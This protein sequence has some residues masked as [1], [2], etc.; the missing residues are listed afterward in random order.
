[1]TDQSEFPPLPSNRSF[2]LL[3]IAVFALLGLWQ[4]W[5]GGSSWIWFGLAGTTGFVTVIAPGLL[6]P[7]N[8]T[9]MHFGLFLHKIVNP[10]VMGAI[11]FCVITPAG[12]LMRIMGR[13]PL[14]RKY[15]RNEKTYWIPRQ[16]PGPEP[17]S[18]KQQ[19]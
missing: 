10:L 8:R 16:P 5:E 18:L 11:F 3:C 17:E 12:I 13:D 9:W 1:M 4:A 14:K 2:G 15:D 19:F 6:T 7:F